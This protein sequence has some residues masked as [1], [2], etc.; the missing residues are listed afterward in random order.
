MNRGGTGEEDKEMRRLVLVA[1]VF[2]LALEIGF[3]CNTLAGKPDKPGRPPE[4]S[5]EKLSWGVDR[6]D[7][8]MVWDRDGDLVVDPGA[9]TGSGIK[10]AILDTGIAEHE[11]LNIQ[12]G[13]NTVGEDPNDHN[14]IDGHGTMMAGVIAALDNNV[15][16][17]G[18]GPDIALYAVK[19]R[20]NLPIIPDENGDRPQLY[21]AMDWC[22]TEGMQVIAMSFTV[23]SVKYDGNGNPQPDKP[24]HD[25]QFYQRIQAASSAGIVLVAAMGNDSAWV[26]VYDPGNPPSGGDMSCYRFPA[27]YPEVIGVSATGLRTGGK[28]DDRGDYFASFSN[29][30]PAVELAAPGVSI[31]TTDIG[32][33][34]NHYTDY[35]GGTSAACPHVAGVAALVLANG[36]APADVRGVLC[37]TAEDLGDPGWDQYFGYGLVDAEKAVLGDTSGAPSRYALCPTDKLS[38]TWG[39]LKGE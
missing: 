18:V 12:D 22:I 15:G 37:T 25:P 36:V 16:F 1:C 28:K 32:L 27:S 39:K 2:V 34:G 7:A 17:I 38:T 19:F 6:I 29:H 31:S 26:D 33:G 21:D 4:E 20:E 14:D 30:G 35:F 5:S 13:T 11:D 9:N 24:E 3:V 10:V 8:D 23:W